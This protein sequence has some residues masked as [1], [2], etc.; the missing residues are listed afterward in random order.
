MNPD[1]ALIFGLI[2]AAFSVPAMVSAWSD[3]RSPRASAIVVLVAG[4]LV[5]YALQTKGG[6]YSLEEIPEVFVRVLAQF[7]N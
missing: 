1:Y 5:I 3:S 6:G 2:L 7:L 4:G